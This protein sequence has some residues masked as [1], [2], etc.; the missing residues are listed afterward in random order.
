MRPRANS[1][2]RS[3]AARPAWQN[4]APPQASPNGSDNAPAP[5]LTDDRPTTAP[6][7][8]PS[9][10]S[11]RCTA[12]LAPRELAIQAP[13]FP[14]TT[15]HP[16][17]GATIPPTTDESGSPAEQCSATPHAPPIKVSRET[18]RSLP[19]R[20][21][22]AD[23]QHSSRAH[24]LPHCRPNARSAPR[25]HAA[26]APRLGD[27][28][29][30]G[31]RRRAALLG[32]TRTRLLPTPVSRRTVAPPAP[33]RPPAS[34]THRPGPRQTP[35][36]TARHRAPGQLKVSL[37]WSRGRALP[38]GKQSG[39]R[40]AH[41]PA[42][43]RLR[44][45]TPPANQFRA[46]RGGGRCPLDPRPSPGRRSGGYSATAPLAAPP[47]RARSRTLNRRIVSII[48]ALRCPKACAGQPWRGG[49]RKC[50]ERDERSRAR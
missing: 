27:P 26:G 33:L 36:K 12:P 20:P 13:Q 42:L 30:W 11:R 7:H 1:A 29:E 44:P 15:C 48:G 46:P 6:G 50:A 31:C 37:P 19:A 47:R 3:S 18:R 49:A 34:G 21:A 10:R 17:T 39:A 25:P 41:R 38:A 8:P 5:T 16:A 2:R 14:A 45:R 23:L 40:S 35:T 24:E 22:S 4:D 32:V 28:A 43:P 9:R